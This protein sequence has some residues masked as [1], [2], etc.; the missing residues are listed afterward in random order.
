MAC[1]GCTVHTYSFCEPWSATWL[2][3]R[4]T[5]TIGWL[6]QPVST[7]IQWEENDVISCEIGIWYLALQSTVSGSKITLS[8]T[9][10]SSCCSCN[11]TCYMLCIIT[12]YLL[13]GAGCIN[14][15]REQ[16]CHSSLQQP[17][18]IIIQAKSHWTSISWS[19]RHLAVPL[20]DMDFC[21]VITMLPGW[22][23]YQHCTTHPIL[24]WLPSKLAEWIADN[25]RT[26]LQTR[27]PAKKVA[28]WTVGE[29][30]QILA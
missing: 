8:I 23:T 29:L 22:V 18:I 1:Q 25:L 5:T 4:R 13:A 11:I 21:S 19:L 26:G 3:M 24:R 30:D 27:I 10:S 15:S 28:K 6:W 17:K 14:V 7:D 12:C 16:H 20:A 9:V 2:M